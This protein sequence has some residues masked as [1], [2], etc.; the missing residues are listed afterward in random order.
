[1]KTLTEKEI[2]NQI[3]EYLS[4]LPEVYAWKNQSVGV[5]DPVKNNFRKPSKYQLNGVSDI[6]GI[7]TQGPNQG[8]MIALEVKSNRG[9]VSDSQKEFLN[10]MEKFGAIWGVVRSLDDTIEL[11]KEYEVIK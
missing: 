2:E 10:N 3:L 1:M 6:I 7:V 11:L 8:R 5:F 4:Y 9:V